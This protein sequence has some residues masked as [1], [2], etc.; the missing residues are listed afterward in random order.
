MNGG[1]K[2][3]LIANFVR[4]GSIRGQQAEQKVK[5]P[6]QGC[7]SEG[8]KINISPGKRQRR[9]LVRAKSRESLHIMFDSLVHWA[10]PKGAVHS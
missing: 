9:T 5:E 3:H 4:R 2:Q 1:S 8:D 10:I 7:R 6:E